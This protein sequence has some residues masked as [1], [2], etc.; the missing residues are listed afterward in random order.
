L[1]EKNVKFFFYNTPDKLVCLSLS[2]S[3]SLYVVYAC[4]CVN[5]GIRPDREAPL[6]QRG[7]NPF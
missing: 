2:L 4:V 1:V 7:Q 5:Y 6:Q 3:L